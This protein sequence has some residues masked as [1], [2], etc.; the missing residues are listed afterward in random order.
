[1][2]DRLIA[3][4]EH[5]E[6]RARVF[7]AGLLCRSSGFDAVPGL[8]YI[9]VLRAGAM[10]IESAGRPG[11]RV[12]RPGVLFYLSPT[13]HWLRPDPDGA[14]TVCASFEFGTGFGNPLGAALPE[15]LWLELAELPTLAAVLASLFAEASG[16]HCGRQAILDRLMEVVIIQLLRALMD[17]DKVGPGLLAGLAD[18]RLARALNA[19]HAEPARAWSLADLA[20]VAGMSRARFAARF[21]TVVGNTP[22]AYLGQWRL[23][24]AQALLRRGLGVQRVAEEVGYANASALSRAF[25]AQL[26]QPPTA[27]LAAYR[28]AGNRG[29][30]NRDGRDARP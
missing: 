5:F 10:R 11:F 19:L 27:W 9:H 24:L 14:D 8:G 29:A 23:G 22:L 13:A 7:Q 15:P 18:R 21:R 25:R 4:L 3:I 26:G 12:E 17:R 28:D 6:L 2:S 20:A 30:G 1:M 16:E